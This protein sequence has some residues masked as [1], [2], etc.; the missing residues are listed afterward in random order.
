MVSAVAQHASE[1]RMVWL[2]VF[3]M[4]QW[5]QDEDGK[6][7]RS[8][9]NLV[10]A[11]VRVVKQVKGLIFVVEMQEDVVKMDFEQVREERMCPIQGLCCVYRALLPTRCQVAPG[12]SCGGG[13]AQWEVVWGRR[14][15]AFYQLAGDR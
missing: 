11:M 12:I 9:F 14:L 3:A 5:D 2:D 7:I 8:T 1:S 13:P 4:R 15:A 10:D 6:P